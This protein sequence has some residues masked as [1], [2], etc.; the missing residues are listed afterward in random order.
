MAIWK[1]DDDWKPSDYD[2]IIEELKAIKHTPT[3]WWRD[4]LVFRE[5]KDSEKPEFDEL[6]SLERMPRHD[7]TVAAEIIKA[8]PDL[9][10]Y[11]TQP[12]AKT[13]SFRT[14]DGR[15][16]IDDLGDGI[17][18]AKIE[19]FWQ[20]Q[21]RALDFVM[22]RAEIEARETAD[23]EALRTGEPGRGEETF[24]TLMKA[25]RARWKKHVDFW[26]RLGMNERR[27][28]VLSQIA[29]RTDVIIN[30]SS[31]DLAPGLFVCHQGV[32]DF[33]NTERSELGDRVELMPHSST[34]LVTQMADVNWD[35]EATAPEFEN[36]MKRVLPEDDLR[37]HLQKALGS[38]FLGEPKD[39][40][41]L[42]LVG[43]PNTGK[44]VL[45]DILKNVLGAYCVFAKPAVFLED[46]FAG[47]ESASPSLH[48]LRKAKLVVSSE[49]DPSKA[50]NSGFL[51]ALTGRDEITSRQLHRGDVT[52]KAK[53][54]LV[55]AS[56]AFIKLDA[57]DEA[58]VRRIHPIPFTQ[59]FRFPE[60]GE[61]WDDIPEAERADRDLTN[62]ILDSEQER[63]GIVNWLVAGLVGY[64]REGLAEPASVAAE[65]VVMT[66]SMSG[67]TE[68]VWSLLDSGQLVRD[69]DGLTQMCAVGL[70]ELHELYV[71]QAEMDG[72][73]SAQIANMKTFKGKVAPIGSRRS[74]DHLPRRHKATPGSSDT[75]Y[76][77]ERLAWSDWK[78]RHGV[79]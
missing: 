22:A 2:N 68:F 67:P 57:A 3:T 58:M 54:L 40:F 76:V 28:A 51:K 77:F 17:I 49:P 12:S 5:V 32:I 26:E 47:S 19:L 46:K 43:P 72:V 23:A 53:F 45:L 1:D 60:A 74:A 62:R 50:Y 15:V 20:Q 65:R 39:K 55:I 6:A 29:D 41:I 25:V 13:G 52:W 27:N 36:Y 61:T 9:F 70:R 11:E 30:E 35:P 31:L 33:K 79:E 14:W 18:S 10:I 71:A 38:H 75:S 24:Q 34:R 8:F 59:R 44:S 56:N 37:W 73:K 4:M 21:R 64:L 7:A 16:W 78:T 63:S 69:P 66:R 48:A 42:N